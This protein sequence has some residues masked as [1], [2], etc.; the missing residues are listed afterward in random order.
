MSGAGDPSR[1]VFTPGSCPDLL[2][3]NRVSGRQ[4]RHRRDEVERSAVR[5][6]DPESLRDGVYDVSIQGKETL[7]LR[8]RT[9]YDEL[10]K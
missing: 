8:R 9:C 10:L 6:R 5:A 2:S 4:P 1:F 3:G 7:C